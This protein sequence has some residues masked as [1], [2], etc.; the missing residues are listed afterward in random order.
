MLELRKRAGFLFFG[1]ILFIILHLYFGLGG[2]LQ[3]SFFDK[4]L[5]LENHFTDGH[6]TETMRWLHFWAWLPTNVAGVTASSIGGYLAY[7]AHKGM[8]FTL[9]FGRGL[10]YLGTAIIVAALTDIFA[11]S[12]IPTILSAENPA[13]QVPVSIHFSAEI[14]G[15]MLCGIGFLGLGKMMIE[16]TRLSED[17]KGFV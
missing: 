10:W 12:V 4:S 17:N 11:L 13:G 14:F 15:L 16:A 1:L 7:L 2:V 8:F 3:Y 9:K 6:V 5:M